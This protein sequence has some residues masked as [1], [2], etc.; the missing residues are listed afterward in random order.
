MKSEW[1]ARNTLMSLSSMWKSVS[2]SRTKK[3]DSFLEYLALNS[4]RIAVV[5]VWSN[6]LVVAKLWMD[7]RF[8][9][10]GVFLL[11]IYFVFSWWIVW[12]KEWRSSG[13]V[14]YFEFDSYLIKTKIRLYI[15]TSVSKILWQRGPFLL[16]SGTKL[17]EVVKLPPP[18]N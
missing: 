16:A 12:K 14:S 10:N 7:S 17:S 2:S 5:F 13:R 15:Y 3:V 4:Q 8:V 1:L 6:F 11:F 18:K 9:F